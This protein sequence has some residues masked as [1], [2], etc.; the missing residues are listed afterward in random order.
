MKKYVLVLSSIVVFVLAASFVLPVGAKNPKSPADYNGLNKGKSDMQHLY[1]YEK[2]SNWDVVP[3]GAWGKMNFSSEKFVFNGHDLEPGVEYALVVYDTICGDDDLTEWPGEGPV[4]G[5]GVAD[6]YGD[7]HI[8]GYFGKGYCEAK[9][10]LVLNDDVDED[11]IF[12]GSWNP[13][14][15]LFEYNRVNV[16]ECACYVGWDLR[17]EYQ[18][19]FVC[20]SG[21]SGT[22]SHM[23]SVDSMDLET[24]EFSGTGYFEPDPDYTWDVNGELDGSNVDFGIVYTGTGAGYT[25]DLVGSVD[26][27][28]VLSGTAESSSSQTFT[29]EVVD[30]VFSPPSCAE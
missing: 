19:D 22:Y 27:D 12:V 3:D 20:T 30:K 1:L 21:C 24:G 15:Y 16:G 9:I 8:K 2:D 18:L 28:G 25:V 23:M 7:V 17:G 6:E 26:V 14:E 13:T 4:L 29:W 11:G 10:W 5:Y